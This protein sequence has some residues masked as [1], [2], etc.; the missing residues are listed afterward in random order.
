MR[1]EASFFVD[2]I[3]HGEFSI[4]MV[5]QEKVMAAMIGG[6]NV[7]AEGISDAMDHYA[8]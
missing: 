7:M 6:P 4:S 3:G 2:T 5:E 1:H 8:S